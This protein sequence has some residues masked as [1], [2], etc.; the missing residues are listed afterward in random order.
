[1]AVDREIDSGSLPV[2]NRFLVSVFFPSLLVKARRQVSLLGIS[3]SPERI[4][5]L[6]RHALGI[7]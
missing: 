4:E 1:M 3:L 7:F 2:E 5:I 6:S